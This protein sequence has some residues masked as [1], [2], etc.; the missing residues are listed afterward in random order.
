MNTALLYCKDPGEYAPVAMGHLRPTSEI[1]YPGRKGLEKAGR[2]VLAQIRGRVQGVSFRAWT[3][4]E[5]ERHALTGWVRNNPDG[6]VSALLA[7]SEPA[8]AAML[9]RLWVGPAGAVVSDVEFYDVEAVH[10]PV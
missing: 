4:R 8:V 2:T 9:E 3:L 6:S 5:A 1:E 7:G 10:V